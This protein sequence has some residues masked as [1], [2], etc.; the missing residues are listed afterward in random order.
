MRFCLLRVTL[1][2]A[3]LLGLTPHTPVFT[4]ASQPVAVDAGEDFFI[5]LG[6]NV[7]TGYNWSQSIADG[8]IVAYEGNVYQNP[9]NGLIGASGQQIFIYH[10]NRT[11]ATTLT[12][13]YARPFEPN[14][15]PVKTVT[16]AVTV[17]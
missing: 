3:F 16:F 4:D 2:A 14:V 15:P 13:S 7:T 1:T 12:F 9:S 11:G 8:K 5:A 6:S 17:K 10:A